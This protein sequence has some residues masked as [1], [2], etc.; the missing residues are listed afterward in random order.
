MEQT[1]I[2]RKATKSKKIFLPHTMYTVRIK[3]HAKNPFGDTVFAK[4]LEHKKERPIY[5][6][7]IH[8][9]DNYMSFSCPDCPAMDTVKK[10]IDDKLWVEILELFQIVSDEK[11]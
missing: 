10:R 7:Y 9:R 2:K 3:K 11:D 8:L 6:L 5:Q 1:E 4:F